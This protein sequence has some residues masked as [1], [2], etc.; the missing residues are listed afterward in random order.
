MVGIADDSVLA[1]R[2]RARSRGWSFRFTGSL[3]CIDA[4]YTRKA[5]HDRR[6]LTQMHLAA[7][8]DMNREAAHS[9]QSELS[10][11]R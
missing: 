11:N 5:A 8:T 9:L 4:G 7:A 6:N 2:Y 3:A 1:F 10:Q